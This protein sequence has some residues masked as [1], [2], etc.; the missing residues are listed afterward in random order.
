MDSSTAN[1]ETPRLLMTGCDLDLID[2]WAHLGQAIRHARRV[3]GI[4]QVDL[5]HRAEV[6][7][8]WLAR[9][10]T[11]HRKAELE[12][13]IRTLGVLGLSFALVP[14]PNEPEDELTEAVRL[15]R[16]R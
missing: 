12:L 16:L 1:S 14:S 4:T 15:A 3:Q 2:H 13:L 8:A 5:A 10:E 7:R 9:V 11:G 6:S